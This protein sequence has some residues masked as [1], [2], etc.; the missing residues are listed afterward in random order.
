MSSTS[1]A[2]IFDTV[3]RRIWAFVRERANLHLMPGTGSYSALFR[4]CLFGE[5]DSAAVAK[6][7]KS[8]RVDVLWLG[9]NPCVPQS[10]EYIINPP[11]GKGD[12]PAFERQDEVW[13]F[14]VSPLG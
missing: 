3:N 9:T 13:T 6:Q 14:W 2:N 4:G 7:L 10:L 8:R 5:K 11:N 12:F 1:R